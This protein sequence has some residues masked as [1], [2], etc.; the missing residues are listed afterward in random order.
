MD[1]QMSYIRSD[2]AGDFIA[3]LVDKDV[4]GAINGSV[5]RTISLCEVIGYMNYLIIILSRLIKLNVKKNSTK[6]N[7]YW[8]K[9]REIENQ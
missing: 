9:R 5:S 4:N 8:R 3:Y 2:E 6:G 7:V 1:Y